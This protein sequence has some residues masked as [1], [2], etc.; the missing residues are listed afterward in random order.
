MKPSFHDIFRF[1]KGKAK[2][3]EDYYD[4]FTSKYLDVVPSA[5]QS[6]RT[7]DESGMFDYYIQAMGLKDGMKL[8]DAGCGVCGPAVYFASKYDIRIDA[9]TNST[10]QLQI[11]KNSIIK[12]GLADKIT[13]NKGDFHFLDNEFVNGTYDV[14]YFLESFGHAYDQR[15]VLESAAKLLN[16]E[17]LIYIKDYF[18]KDVKD[19]KAIKIVSRNMNKKYFYNLPD[20]YFT[21][22]VLRNLDFEIVKIGVPGFEHDNGAKALEFENNNNI[23]L[24]GRIPVISYADPLELCFRKYKMFK[25]VS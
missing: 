25:T 12:N 18:K 11:A 3:V 5:I 2:K 4:N 20:F 21:I 17:G 9:V 16:K 8:M 19:M 6:H 24:F 10:V 15:K 7:T 23:E 1:T 13:V 22:H 14:V